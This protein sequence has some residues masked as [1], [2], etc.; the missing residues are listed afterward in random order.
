MRI[1]WISY[2]EIKLGS[3]N[4]RVWMAFGH[5]KWRI[6][7]GKKITRHEEIKTWAAGVVDGLPATH[8]ALKV[9][10]IMARSEVGENRLGRLLG[11]N[12]EVN[13]WQNQIGHSVFII[14]AI[15]VIIVIININMTFWV[16][17]GGTHVLWFTRRGQETSCMSRFCSSAIWVSGIKFRSPG[18]VAGTSS[19]RARPITGFNWT[20]TPQSRRWEKARWE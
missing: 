6:W 15:I 2:W 8:D 9:S 19:Q 13:G 4:G 12:G 20:V 11:S 3:D 14:I 5:E 16:C 18:L 1:L 17:G 10:R 7:E